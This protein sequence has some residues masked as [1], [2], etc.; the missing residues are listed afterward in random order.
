MEHE[1]S[2]KFHWR[3]HSQGHKWIYPDCQYFQC[4]DVCFFFFF[5]LHMQVCTAGDG[6][7]R[8]GMLTSVFRMLTKCLHSFTPSGLFP[9]LLANR[10][11]TFPLPSLS[12]ALWC[13]LFASKG[14]TVQP[15][16]GRPH[17]LDRK[18]YCDGCRS[19]HIFACAATC[20]LVSAATVWVCGVCCTLSYVAE[21]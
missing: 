4:T 16:L 6:D 3:M 18:V 12:N 7:N 10:G 8:W 11:T 9:F 13:R 2:V 19:P 14:R 21:K 1:V 15:G 20:I 17:K 5:S